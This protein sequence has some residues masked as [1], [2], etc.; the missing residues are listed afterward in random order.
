MARGGAVGMGARAAERG[1]REAAGGAREAKVEALDL[2]SLRNRFP[3]N[4]LHILRQ[5]HHRRIH[6]QMHSCNHWSSSLSLRTSRGTPSGMQQ[7][8]SSLAVGLLEAPTTICCMQRRHVCIHK[9]GTRERQ[10]R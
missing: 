4:T 1:A 5:G 8:H 3:M 6:R 7:A 10:R 2:R 9:T